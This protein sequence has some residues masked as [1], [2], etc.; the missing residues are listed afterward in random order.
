[1]KVR[2]RDGFTPRVNQVNGR[3]RRVV[4]RGGQASLDTRDLVRET[5]RRAIERIFK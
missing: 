5:V 2:V 1:M 4:R 3:L